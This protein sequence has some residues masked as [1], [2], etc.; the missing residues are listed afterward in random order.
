MKQA[1]LGDDIV[2]AFDDRQRLSIILVVS[3]Y[4]ATPRSKTPLGRILLIKDEE[5]QIK[6][7]VSVHW[8][9]S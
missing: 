9:A 7:Q 8:F 6:I 2:S 5:A 1:S 4:L 3:I